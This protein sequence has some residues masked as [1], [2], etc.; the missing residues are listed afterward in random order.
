MSLEKAID[1]L[2][3]S[4]YKNGNSKRRSDI[5]K[6]HSEIRAKLEEL[7]LESRKILAEILQD[8]MAEIP[9]AYE[10][11]L[12]VSA[13]SEYDDNGSTYEY[14]TY[15][16]ELRNK[17]FKEISISKDELSDIDRLIEDNRGLFDESF[18]ICEIKDS[19]ENPAIFIFK[20]KS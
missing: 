13:D 2:E 3:S 20:S 16:L 7:K 9:E 11:L 5:F 15:S 17:N 1:T 12:F 14:L 6:K 19:E 18:S 4:I 10:C 8:F